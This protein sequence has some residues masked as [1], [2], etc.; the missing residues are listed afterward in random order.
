MSKVILILSEGNDANLCS[1][2]AEDYPGGKEPAVGDL[3]PLRASATYKLS[4]DS[5]K[6]E[7][8]EIPYLNGLYEVIRVRK[9]KGYD[10]HPKA[11]GAPSYTL[12]ET[13]EGYGI[14][15]SRE[16]LPLDDTMQPIEARVDF[17]T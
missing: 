16:H 3:I 13:I 8:T 11:K 17:G 7:P 4:F 10:L 2:A 9:G 14:T 5:G 1:I 12:D 15:L 6:S